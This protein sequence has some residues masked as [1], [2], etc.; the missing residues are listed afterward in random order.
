[1]S[2][3]ERLVRI[4]AKSPIFSIAGPEVCLV[5]ASNIILNTLKKKIKDVRMRLI[6]C[7]E[8]SALDKI[9]SGECHIAVICG[10][11]AE[12]FI[13]KVI[14]KVTFVT[15]A[16]ESHPLIAGK[17]KLSFP[18][19]EVLKHPFVKG[20]HPFFG[21]IKLQDNN[22][23]GWRDDKFP[24]LV[25]YVSTSLKIIDHF[26]LNGDAL[27]YLP[28]YYAQA[29]NVKVLQVTGCPYTCE[30]KLKMVISRSSPFH[31]LKDVLD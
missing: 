15:C 30:Q 16:G 23:D 21:E 8:E 18:I 26:L 13:G 20:D 31:W 1:M 5:Y 22:I 11:Y 6:P 12:R 2:P 17:K 28:D 10:P 7:S 14:R 27:A 29:L 19:E 3:E 25:S 24:R 4:E 9:D